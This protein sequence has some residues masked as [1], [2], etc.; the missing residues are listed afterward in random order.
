MSVCVCVCVCGWVG[1]WVSVCVCVSVGVWVGGWVGVVSVIV[2][3]P[4][5]TPCVIDG[6]SRNSLYYYYVTLGVFLAWCVLRLV[7]FTCTEA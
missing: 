2:K 6:P 5:L 4:V 7:C 3:R 1:G